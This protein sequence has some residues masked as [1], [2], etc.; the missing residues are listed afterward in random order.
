MVSF[1]KLRPEILFELPDLSAQGR[2]CDVKFGRSAGKVQLFGDSGDVAIQ[3]EFDTREHADSKRDPEP[4]RIP[5]QR[6]V[7]PSELSRD[8]ACLAQ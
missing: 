7:N 8:Q 5:V 6:M 3:P 1:K 2:L 4:A